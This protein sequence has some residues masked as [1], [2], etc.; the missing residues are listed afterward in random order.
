MKNSSPRLA[1][2]HRPRGNMLLLVL[3]AVIVVIVGAV[4]AWWFLGRGTGEGAPQVLVNRVSRGPY[5][6]VVIEQGE[7]ESASNLE[8]RCEVRSRGGGGGGGGSGGGG[9]GTTIIDV[10]AEG[11]RVTGPAVAEDPVIDPLARL[12]ELPPRD[13]HG[14]AI[15]AV[16]SKFPGS[17]IKSVK[18]IIAPKDQKDPPYDY[19]I[20]VETSE[21]REANLGVKHGTRLVLLDSSTLDQERVTQLIKVNGQKSLV[22]QAENTLKASKIALLEY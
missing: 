12:E 19:Q 11:T 6:Y 1:R 10:I 8:L 5:D 21:G 14:N 4:L 16:R 22:A 9:G 2:R 18:R 13:L 15:E 3:A 17:T 7:V 20:V